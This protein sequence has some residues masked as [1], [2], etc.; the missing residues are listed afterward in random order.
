MRR[1]VDQHPSALAVPRPSPRPAIVVRLRAEP[2]R[3]DHLDAEDLSDRPA[4]DQLL[5]LSH[6]R[7]RALLQHRTERHLAA[8]AFGDHRPCV[9]HGGG[10]RLLAQDVDAPAGSPHRQRGMPVMRCRD[11]GRVDRPRVVHRLGAAEERNA[12]LSRDRPL[13]R[14]DVAD[15]A[16]GHRPPAVLLD[17]PGMG[18]AYDAQPDHAE[19]NLLHRS[20]L[21][22]G[23]LRSARVD[24]NPAPVEI[25]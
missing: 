22:A 13:L 9:A 6:H 19:S 17:P 10:Q 3:A 20:L 23:R 5:H 4:I 25:R 7:A 8:P 21:I 15:G 24:C 16:Q 18:L 1:L 2:A 14:E 11:D 12:K